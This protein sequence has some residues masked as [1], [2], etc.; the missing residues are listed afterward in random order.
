MTSGDTNAKTVALLKKHGN[1][2]MDD[3]Q[4]TIVQQGQG[5]P[6]LSDNNAAIALD[7]RERDALLK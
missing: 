6:A 4:I 3:D 1:F 2:G 5:V 7:P